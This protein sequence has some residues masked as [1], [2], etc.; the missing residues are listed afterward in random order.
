M[1]KTGLVG[2]S[3]APAESRN[4]EATAARIPARMRHRIA[5][6]GAGLLARRCKVGR[7]GKPDRLGD[8]LIGFGY[9][10]DLA[11]ELEGGGTRDLSLRHD[12]VQRFA[13]TLIGIGKLGDPA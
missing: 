8:R 3:A 6:G 11:I 10:A 2:I 9:P 7:P 4:T 5:P 13:R 1:R 12:V